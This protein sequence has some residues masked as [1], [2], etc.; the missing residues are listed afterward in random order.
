VP[1]FVGRGALPACIL[2]KTGMST[3]TATA[4]VAQ[5]CRQATADLGHG[6]PSQSS[7]WVHG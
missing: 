6:T 2:G 4:G 7:Q 1:I 5:A 3:A